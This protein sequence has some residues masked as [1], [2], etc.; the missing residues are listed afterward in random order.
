MDKRWKRAERSVARALGTKRVGPTGRDTFDCISPEYR[1]GVEVKSKERFPKWLTSAMEQAEDHYRALE[2]RDKCDT[3]MAIPMVALVEK[4]M[5]T[6]DVLCIL[7]L[8]DF[9]F[10]VGT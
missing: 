6:D 5:K 4:G 8:K 3:P 10:L 7:R 9:K 2:G 1:V